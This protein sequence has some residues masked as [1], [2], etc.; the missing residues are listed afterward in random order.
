MLDRIAE[1]IFAFTDDLRL[2]GGMNLPAR[3][4]LI[5]RDGKVLV[6]S[7]LA[8]DD[9]RAAEIETLGDVD[10]IVAPSCIHYLFLERAAKRWPNARVLG[11]TGLEKKVPTVSFAP[12]PAEGKIEGLRVRR[13][14]G[15]PYI[16][17]HVFLDE[18]TGSLVVTDLIFNIHA[19]R[20]VGMKMFLLAVGAWDKPAQS[21]F[22]RYLFSR[23][24]QAG[25]RSVRDVLAWDFD[26]IVVAHGDVVDSDAKPRLER[27]LAWLALQRLSAA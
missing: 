27:A 24:L 10:A 9:A 20:D 6:H 2:P 15:F 23:D 8:I 14:D 3:T 26:R 22:W 4:T 11:A 13:I 5:R 1:D 7:P 17:E 19:V 21:R 16:G 18:R 12:L 25:A